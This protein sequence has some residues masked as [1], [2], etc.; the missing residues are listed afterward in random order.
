MSRGCCF[1]IIIFCVLAGCVGVDE[2]RDFFFQNGHNHYIQKD[3]TS[4][5]L[6]FNNAIHVDPDFGEGYKRIAD[7]YTWQNRWGDAERLYRKAIALNPKLLGAH[8]ALAEILVMDNSIEEARACI[9]SILTDFPDNDRALFLSGILYFNENRPEEASAVLKGIISSVDPT[10]PCY[11]LSRFLI[12]EPQVDLAALKDRKDVISLPF[13][14]ITSACAFT[15]FDYAKETSRRKLTGLISVFNEFMAE[16][17]YSKEFKWFT[18]AI[19]KAA[20]DNR[21]IDSNL[22]NILNGINM[23]NEEKKVQTMEPMKSNDSFVKNNYSS[24][25]SKPVMILVGSLMFVLILFNRSRF[26]EK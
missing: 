17:F 13:I 25:L 24:L 6:D 18:V 1:L 3:Y 11:I 7:C 5:E 21:T 26:G 4:A 9:D 16:N 23:M 14:M 10:T 20:L 8:L 2:K 22:I 19:A 15:Q 12:K